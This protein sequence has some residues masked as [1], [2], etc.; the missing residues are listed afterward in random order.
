MTQQL[1]KSSNLHIIQ[2]GADLIHVSLIWLENS[3]SFSKGPDANVRN[4]SSVDV[5]CWLNDGLVSRKKFGIVLFIF[6]QPLSHGIGD[7]N[8]TYTRGC[9]NTQLRHRV[10]MELISELWLCVSSNRH[11]LLQSACAEERRRLSLHDEVQ[12]AHHWLL[13]SG[14][15]GDAW[16]PTPGW[17][18]PP[19]V[20]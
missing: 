10:P 17:K 12:T 13:L 5:G 18:W 7:R 14:E 9:S 6:H 1:R 15:D 16:S 3:A 11:S 2:F 20:T 4:G 19:Q 8:Q